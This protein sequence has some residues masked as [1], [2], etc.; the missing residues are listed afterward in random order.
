MKRR[1]VLDGV[2]RRLGVVDQQA[3]RG[4]DDRLHVA[5]RRIAAGE[6]KQVWPIFTVGRSAVNT[7]AVDPA[8]GRLADSQS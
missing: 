6:A 4:S 3:G 7:L 1:R 2:L 5:N 8:F